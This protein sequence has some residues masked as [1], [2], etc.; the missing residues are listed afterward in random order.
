LPDGLPVGMMRSWYGRLADVPGAG[1]PGSPDVDRGQLRW[2]NIQPDIHEPVTLPGRELASDRD[3]DR[4]W[5][6]YPDDYAT[7]ESPADRHWSGA[8]TSRMRADQVL[9]RLYEALEL[10]GTLNDYHFII[11]AAAGDLELKARADP[12]LFTLVEELC[13]LDLRIVGVDPELFSYVDAQGERHQYRVPACDI[14]ARMYRS[15]GALREWLAVEEQAA[16]L[17]QGD[18][19]RVRALIAE[20]ESDAG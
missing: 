20:L 7:S 19:D 10:P 13:K 3:V 5:W 9:R 1:Y 8:E 17:S 16:Q 18:P 12:A 15:E 4:Y 2:A 11:M 6:E 14:L